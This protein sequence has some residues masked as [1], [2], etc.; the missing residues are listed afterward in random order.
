M[1][2][3]FDDKRENGEVSDVFSFANRHVVV[4]LENA[5]HIGYAKLEDVRS[6]IE[7]LVREELKGKKI[8]EKLM[9]FVDK[10][11]S[12]AELARLAGATLI[13]IESLKMS[14]NFIPQ[15]AAEMKILGALFGVELKKF[16]TPVIGKSNTAIIWVDKRDDI[17]VP[18]SAGEAPD[19]FEMYNR[20][21]Y[22]M[23]TLQEVLTKKANIQDYRYKYEWF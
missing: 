17:K 1:Y 8:A 4:M 21:N 14:Q 16:S 6:E 20:P 19:A 7:P 11:K 15:I 12:P 2:W 22:V 23:N 5:K 13:P 9:S 3:L 10:A 18:K